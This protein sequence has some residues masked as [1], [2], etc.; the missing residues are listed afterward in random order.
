MDYDLISEEEYAGLPDDDEECF[1]A[2]EAICRRNMNRM[3]N[4]DTSH[5]FDWTIKSQYM[6]AVSSVGEEC[7]IPNIKMGAY[8]EQEFHETFSR[9]CLAVHGEIA[10]IRIRGRGMRHPYSVQ[11]AP[12]TRTKIEHHISRIRHTI[13]ASDLS[14]DRRK[15]LGAKLD[16]LTAELANRRIG[17]GKTMAVLSTRNVS[18]T[19]IQP[20]LAFKLG[21]LALP[22]VD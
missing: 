9:F 7:G 18:T 1:V 2:F 15:A 22:L 12:N 14:S 20:G 4:E 6:S 10:R 5:E 11:L 3:I 19:L 13:D 16:E 21:S 17:F 8:N